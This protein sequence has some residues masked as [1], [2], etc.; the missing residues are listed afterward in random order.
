MGK[1]IL[2]F[3][4]LFFY[5]CISLSGEEAKSDIGKVFFSNGEEWVGTLSM[6]QDNKLQ[7]NTDLGMKFL[8]LEQIREMK[9]IPEKQIMEQKWFLPEAGKPH[10][11]KNG[12]PYPVQHLRAEIILKTGEKLSG[13][14][15]SSVLY[16]YSADGEKK[17]IVL[18][19]KQRG[20]EGETF[21]NLLYPE[22]IILSDGTE[23]AVGNNMVIEIPKNYLHQG[24]EISALNIPDLLN[25][26]ITE[27][28]DTIIANGEFA[29]GIFVAL[30]KDNE[31]IVFW[32]TEKDEELFEKLKNGV[33]EMKDFFDHRE[34][35]AVY[36]PNKGSTVFSL[37]L[38]LREGKT[39]L[40][41]EKSNPWRLMIQRWKYDAESGKLLLSGNGWLFRGIDKRGETCP[42]LKI[43]NEKCGLKKL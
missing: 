13:H 38:M 37:T 8:L 28:K 32:E 18:M 4:F 22:R 12:A 23:K 35:K 3:Y 29:E 30:K 7:I 24:Y 16:L 25:V 14:L 6:T 31:I 15:Y 33:A 36:W 20:K 21:K 34:L 11:E 17:R 10:K 40:N 43:S 39:S 9:F 27:D 19:S 42:T 41:A 26:K 2:S 1:N 5:F